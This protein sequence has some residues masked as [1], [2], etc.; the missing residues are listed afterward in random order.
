MWQD[1]RLGGIPPT[2]SF[3]VRRVVLLGGGGEGEL[4]EMSGR[5]WC[6]TGCSGVT[7]ARSREDQGE[8]MDLGWLRFFR[9]VVAAVMM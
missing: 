8:C 7:A 5:R 1:T 6:A 9:W 2:R 4:W 3:F